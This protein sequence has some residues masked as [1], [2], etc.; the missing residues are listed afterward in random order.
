MVP[1]KTVAPTIKCVLP[2]RIAE[3][4]SIGSATIASTRP[5]PW[6]MLLAISSRTLTTRGQS[7]ISSDC[8][9][10]RQVL[11]H[12]RLGQRRKPGQRVAVE[13]LCLPRGA[14]PVAILVADDLHRHDHDV[15]AELV[16]RRNPVVK[17]PARLDR[18]L[19]RARELVVP[20]QLE[21][22]FAGVRRERE[23][24]L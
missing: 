18:E 2:I 16:R 4:M 8:T 22:V 23:D 7:F 11:G 24:I 14:V 13:R 20:Q 15:G 1:P 21:F 17:L 19:D 3:R 6:L 5:R 12:E 9:R 10:T